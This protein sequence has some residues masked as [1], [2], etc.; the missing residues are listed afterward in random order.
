MNK[1][2][3]GETV[4][5][6]LKCASQK[7][8]QRNEKPLDSASRRIESTGGQLI[9]MTSFLTNNDCSHHW[10]NLSPSQCNFHT[11]RCSGRENKT[12]SYLYFSVKASK[13]IRHFHPTSALRRAKIC[14]FRRRFDR[15]EPSKIRRQMDTSPENKGKTFPTCN[16]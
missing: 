6:L 7:A 1:N 4:V 11:I 16:S 5:L 12:H 3:Y 8:D 2:T 13:L 10:S 14:R 15:S 9:S